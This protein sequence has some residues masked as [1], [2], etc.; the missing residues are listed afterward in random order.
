MDTEELAGT[1]EPDIIIQVWCGIEVAM[2]VRTVLSV[3]SV[4][5]EKL[6]IEDVDTAVQRNERSIKQMQDQEKESIPGEQEIQDKERDR[7]QKHTKRAKEG[8]LIVPL[9][10]ARLLL[11]DEEG[12]ALLVA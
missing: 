10:R 5:R 11:L 9:R 3:F 8:S 7:R 4:E 2:N 6:K 1:K 12:K